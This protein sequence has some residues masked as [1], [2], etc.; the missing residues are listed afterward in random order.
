MIKPFH[1]IVI[2]AQTDLPIPSHHEWVATN[3][4]GS[5]VSFMHQPEFLFEAGVWQAA[6]GDQPS[7]V[8][9]SPCKFRAN[10]EA[11]LYHYPLE[12]S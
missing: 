2:Y 3:A 6:E 9:I 10:A 5:I 7:I 12:K 4:D 1:R 8:A 11:S